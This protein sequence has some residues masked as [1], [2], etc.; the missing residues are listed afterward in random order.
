M[1]TENTYSSAGTVGTID[2]VIIDRGL[3]GWKGGGS[4]WLWLKAEVEQKDQ[5]GPPYSKKLLW[6]NAC[7]IKPRIQYKGE[8][9][10]FF[11][12]RQQLLTAGIIS[13][14]LPFT[15]CT[16]ITLPWLKHMDYC[17]SRATRPLEEQTLQLNFYGAVGGLRQLHFC[18]LKEHSSAGCNRAAL[19]PGLKAAAVRRVWCGCMQT[20][21]RLTTL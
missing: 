16:I 2:T 21:C 20:S 1:D 9:L 8:C 15:I 6:L 13:R 4:V 17:L 14:W 10:Y 12:S 7:I 19:C 3:K 18:G 11:T 5:L